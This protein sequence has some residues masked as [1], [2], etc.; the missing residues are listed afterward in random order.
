M[1]QIT[2]IEETTFGEIDYEVTKI[3]GP[4]VRDPEVWIPFTV[5]TGTIF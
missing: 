4:P 1:V 3:D 5:N 2:K